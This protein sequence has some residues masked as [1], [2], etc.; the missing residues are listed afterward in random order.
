MVQDLVPHVGHRQVDV[1]KVRIKHDRNSRIHTWERMMNRF[2]IALICLAFWT[3]AAVAQSDVHEVAG[4]RCG[5]WKNGEVVP[6]PSGPPDHGACIWDN[7]S[8][9]AWWSGVNKGYINLDWGKLPVPSSGLPDH[10][11]DGFTFAYGTNNR[12]P[13]G[14]DFAVYYYDSC[15]GWGNLGVH[16]AA[17]FFHGLPNAYGFPT[18]PPGYGWVWSVTCDIEGTGYE[19]LLGQELG[20]GMIRL[21]TPTMGSSGLAIGGRIPGNG[22][23]NAFD[24]YGCK[25]LPTHNHAA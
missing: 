13:A 15:T 18:L 19:F 11:I 3:G 17:F 6:M 16:E 12:D 5:L 20:N 24:I 1:S 2:V 14:D 25:F 23:E 8:I 4:V 10:V 22:I 9:S 7:Y 21:L